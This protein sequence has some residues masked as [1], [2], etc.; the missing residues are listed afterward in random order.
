MGKTA[1]AL[2]IARNVAFDLEK[3]V[4]IFSLEMSDTQIF[5]RFFGTVSGIKETVIVLQIA[6]GVKI[7]ILKTAVSTVVERKPE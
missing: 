6:D 3:T 2:N 7:E 5:D 1:L 4:G